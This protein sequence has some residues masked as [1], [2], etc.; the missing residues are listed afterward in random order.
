MGVNKYGQVIGYISLAS[1][2][3]SWFNFRPVE[4]A[5]VLDV[6][7]MMGIPSGWEMSLQGSRLC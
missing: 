4:K 5:L 1:P 2:T 6:P 7:T 3:A